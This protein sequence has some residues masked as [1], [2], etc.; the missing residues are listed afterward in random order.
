MTDI[1]KALEVIDEISK[2]R[3][4]EGAR[5][6]LETLITEISSRIDAVNEDL[7]SQAEAEKTDDD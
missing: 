6:F 5:Y 3:S 4:L 2:R 7:R 1:S